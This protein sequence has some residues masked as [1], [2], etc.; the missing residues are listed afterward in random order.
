MVELNSDD[1]RYY[2]DRVDTLLHQFSGL[3]TGSTSSKKR[4][5]GASEETGLFKKAISSATD[6]L[7]LLH[8]STEHA[9][10]A[11][12]EVVGWGAM[13][14]ALMTLI[15]H[16]GDVSK[17]YGKLIDVG[18]TF[19][20]SM[21]E[22]QR[23]AGDSGLTLEQFASSVTKGSAAI[24]S[25]G[26]NQTNAIESFNKYQ[27]GVRS[28]L[29]QF[30][31]YGMSLSDLTDVTA[32]YADT[33]RMTGHWEKLGN[34][35]RSK[36][37]SDFIQSIQGLA[38]AAGT[39]RD[40]LMKQA[41]DV[42]KQPDMG[43][44]LAAMTESQMQNVTATLASVG[45]NLGEPVKK[46]AEDW[47]KYGGQMQFSPEAQKW[48]DAG[49]SKQIDQVSL[50]MEN[51]MRG[52][53]VGSEEFF[54]RQKAIVDS[55][56]RDDRLRPGGMMQA[57]NPEMYAAAQTAVMTARGRLDNA[58]EAAQRFA[59]AMNKS[60]EPV[61]RALVLFKSNL[62]LTTGAFRK[63]FYDGIVTSMLHGSDDVTA[64]NDSLK[65]LDDTLEDFGK[66]A[67]VVFSLLIDVIPALVGAFEVLAFVVSN[68]S[69]FFEGMFK[70]VGLGGSSTPKW[71]QENGH[72]KIDLKTG[73]RI[74]VWQ[75]D[76]NGKDAI[77]PTTGKKIQE[78]NET[79]NY[80]KVLGATITVG[81]TAF[82]AIWLKRRIS[83]AMHLN[84]RDVYLTSKSI[85]GANGKPVFEHTSR[86]AEFDLQG[87]NAGKGAA[88]K[89]RMAR[90]FGP[91]SKLGRAGSFIGS[92]YSTQAAETVTTEAEATVRSTATK[93]RWFRSGSK[94]GMVGKF[95]LRGIVGF[96]GGMILDGVINQ[97][98][99]STTKDTIE[100]LMPW[101]GAA[102]SVFG[103]QLL[104]LVTRGLFSSVTKAA[105]A[106]TEE[107][108]AA[109]AVAAAGGTAGLS[110]VGKNLLSWVLKRLVVG[111]AI[112]EALATIDSDD[113]MGD[114]I[115]RHVP[116]A[117]SFDDFMAR[118][119]G[120]GRTRQQ[121]AE[122]Q[123]A[124]DAKNKKN[125][126][127]E[128]KRQ[129]ISPEQKAKIDKQHEG[130]ILWDPNPLHW[131]GFGRTNAAPP[132]KDQAA[133]A[134][135]TPLD[136]IAAM[137]DMLPAISGMLN[138]GIEPLQNRATAD[139]LSGAISDVLTDP[140]HSFLTA[141]VNAQTDTFE[142]L[143]RR[144]L[145]LA[146]LIAIDQQKQA[147]GDDPKV[148]AEIELAKAQLEQLQHQTA[149]LYKGNNQR[150]DANRLSQSL[151]T[152]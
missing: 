34:L 130:S 10:H 133:E 48:R 107:T 25:L 38:A 41:M 57:A 33:L 17:T 99:D 88:P 84:A 31:F 32:S 151:F 104:G 90:W 21:F 7:K 108:V 144:L 143:N 141:P 49:M 66:S 5:G 52:V 93:G 111:F 64:F 20:G 96:A 140:N 86:Q 121:Q 109:E 138:A 50:I 36:A 22:M 118:Y 37:T 82:F 85:L 149:L 70:A 18:Q 76:E 4:S 91:Q 51:S 103:P 87:G 134:P 1:L 124:I 137:R 29:Q 23:Q 6:S 8:G 30:G 28:N 150:D 56:S 119:T 112:H 129:G 75:K 12:R 24:V 72:D 46:L 101:A 92:L 3:G 11:L 80:A 59:D 45:A 42:A 98:P 128:Y 146:A 65:K 15:G 14:G 100:Q 132:T 19:G 89:G 83:G 94:F 114:W 95:L 63:G 127:E 145:D 27:K 131:F 35:E 77:D 116:G 26:A 61:T 136:K 139:V 102:L 54:A 152:P 106:A 147:Q 148:K 16:I 113:S 78:R 53:K 69:S 55:I 120:F 105:A 2:F 97:L 142:S 44:A 125:E 122:A 47:V 39:S 71:E 73:Q 43:A 74:P 13:G 117:A 115:D 58:S 67:G 79:T 81:L 60:M 62:E 135:A 9:S 68:V 40:E 123:Q 110:M 126:E